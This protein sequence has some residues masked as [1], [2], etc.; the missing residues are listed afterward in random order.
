MGFA[1]SLPL[2]LVIE[3]VLCLLLFFFFFSFFFIFFFGFLKFSKQS[4]ISAF[5]QGRGKE[6]EVPH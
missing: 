3:H 6:Y 2:Y 5:F 1:I 4:D